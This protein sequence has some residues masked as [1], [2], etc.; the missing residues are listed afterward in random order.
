MS[1]R[2]DA[3]KRLKGNFPILSAEFQRKELVLC[4]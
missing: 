4:R 2:I 3:V 1:N